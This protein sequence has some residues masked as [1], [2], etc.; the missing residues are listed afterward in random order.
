MNQKQDFEDMKG[1]GKHK[2]FHKSAD[3]NEDH[4][5]IKNS[6]MLAFFEDIDLLDNKDSL[7]HADDMQ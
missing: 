4:L 3:D 2:R 1:Q 5:D 6:D 7:D